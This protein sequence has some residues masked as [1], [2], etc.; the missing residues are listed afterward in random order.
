VRVILVPHILAG[1]LGIVAGFV[2]LYATKGATLHRKSGMIF[3]YAMLVLSGSGA[4]MAMTWRPNTGNVMAGVLTFYL[5]LT[6]VL[7]VRRS[8][9]WLDF[10]AMLVGL[11]GGLSGIA[12]GFDAI[13]RGG[14]RQGI[15]A[16]VF[17]TFGAIGLLAI[18]GDVRMI[19]S[20]RPARRASTR[21]APVAHVSWSP[22]CRRLIFPWSA[23]QSPRDDP[24]SCSSPNSSIGAACGDVVLAAAN[25]R[26]TGLSRHCWRRSTRGRMK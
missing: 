3:V 2:A 9:P 25:S 6:A 10:G 7:T 5:V 13:A 4:L 18:T 23:G 26:Q 12:L 11:A 21:K 19:R 24:N 17:F 22:D 14:I 20:G 8:A 1:G 15:P 16:P